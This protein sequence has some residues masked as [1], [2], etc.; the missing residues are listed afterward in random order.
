MRV[1]ARRLGRFAEDRILTEAQGGFRSHRGSSNQ[2]LALKGMCE[3]GR[4]RDGDAD[5]VGGF[6]HM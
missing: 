4:Q 2:W 1:M 6:R 3:F 5:Y